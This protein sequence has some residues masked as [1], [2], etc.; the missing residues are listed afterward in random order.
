MNIKRNYG[1]PI[2]L[3]LS[4]LPVLM[5]LAETSILARFSDWV[6][7]LT[8]IGQLLGLIGVAMFAVN[9]ILSARLPFFE[10]YFHGLNDLYVRHSQLGQL[11]LMMLL[12]HPLFLLMQYSGGTFYGAAMFLLPGRDWALN[13][14]IISLG[15]MIFLIILTLYLRPKYN[16]WKFTH[17]FLGFAF[18]LGALHAFLIPSDISRDMF[19]RTYILGISFIAIVAF[20][21]RSLLDRFTVPRYRYLIKEVKLLSNEVTQI[22]MTPVSKV[23]KFKA[24]QFGFVRFFDKS[25]GK[26]VHPYSFSSNP[27]DAVLSITVK[28]LGDYT[29]N[30]SA[31]SE[32]SVVEIE[33]PFGIFSH[34]N[35]ASKNQIWVGGG[36]GITP[37]TSMAH[38]LKPN[39][40]FNIDL[41]YCVRDSAEAVMMTELEAIA[42]NLNGELKIFEFCSTRKGRFSMDAIIEHS[43]TL[44]NKDIFICAPPAMI[45]SLK[46]Q[47]IS[48]GI[49]PSRLHSEEFSF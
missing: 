18:F 28:K 46:E 5:W 25:V 24:G 47:F 33:G 30:I 39:D 8:S 40:G 34:E 22:F 4:F 26:E 14:G 11:A 44:E 48:K 38:S 45:K 15:S 49:K 19:L 12:F 32:C 13:F 3:G 2:V 36:I 23:M 20:C 7:G 41:Y 10:K 9:L 35:A 29:Q 31:L 37:F 17:K 6:T 16:L 27:D 42:K 43:G 21:Y 1:W